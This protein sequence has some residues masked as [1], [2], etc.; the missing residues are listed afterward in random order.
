MTQSISVIIPAYNHLS[1]VLACLTSLQTFA[2]KTIDMQFLV[3]DDCSPDVFFPAVLPPCAASAARNPVNLGFGGNCNAGAARAQGDILFFVNQDVMAIGQD[4]YGK[5]LSQSWDIPLVQTFDNPEVG[6][7]GAKLLFPD[8]R[9]QNAGGKLDGACQP[10]HRGLGY[11]NH[12]YYEVNTPEFVTW[13]TGAALAIRRDLFNQ[14]NGFDTI[15]GRGYFEDIDLCLRA[16]ELGA[17]TWYEPQCVFVHHVGTSGGSS[18]FS[19]NAQIFKRKWVD[20]K[21]IKPDFSA[22]RERFW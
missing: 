20:T 22:I 10:T 11:S 3:Q 4:A 18:T 17:K 1:E 14:L 5:P 2:S 15:Y 21:R 13:T 7:A 12:R 8:G 19:Q 16:N 9:I 6:I